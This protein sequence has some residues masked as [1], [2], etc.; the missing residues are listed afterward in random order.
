MSRRS[1]A[2]TGRGVLGVYLALTALFFGLHTLL[3]VL[4]PATAVSLGASA[5]VSGVVLVLYTGLG[6][7]TD[8]PLG[9][10][11]QALGVRAVVL[12]GCAVMLAGSAALLRVSDLTGLVVVSAV[13]GV[14]TSFVLGPILGG[15]A[16]TVGER[17]RGPQELNAGVQRVGALAASLFVGHALAGGRTGSAAVGVLVIV[18]LLALTVLALPRRGATRSAAAGRAH[19]GQL[20]AQAVRRGAGVYLQAGRLLVRS[21]AVA[22]GVTVNGLIPTLMIFGSSFFPVLLVAQQQVQLVTAALI[23]REGVAVLTVLAAGTAWRRVPIRTLLLVA[24][25]PAAASF[26]ALPWVQH[27]V[28]VVALFA[29]HGAAMGLGIVASNVH[30]YEGTTERDRMA[31]FAVAGTTSRVAGIAVPLVLG[32]ATDRSAVALTVSVTAITAV[33]ALLYAAL[34][35]RPAG[36]RPPVGQALVDAISHRSEEN[37]ATQDHP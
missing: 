21:R 9:R 14:G 18:V 36:P 8:V 16:G 6:I 13:L 30:I 35:R 20:V 7:V 2:R 24:L 5:S 22:S 10:A 11:A 31:G 4:L 25:V 19:P 26:L 29:V 17:Q 12:T 15:L 32:V 27:P 1:G 3:L 33:L 28:A 23:A 37:R 34:Q